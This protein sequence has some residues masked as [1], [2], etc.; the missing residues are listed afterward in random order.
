MLIKALQQILC[1]LMHLGELIQALANGV[2]NLEEA[3]RR[4]RSQLVDISERLT[5]WLQG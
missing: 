1:P 4:R 3:V 2:I 5:L